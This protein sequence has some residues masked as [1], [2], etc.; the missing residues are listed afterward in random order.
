M[1]IDGGF[2]GSGSGGRYG[3]A[4]GGGAVYVVHKSMGT[5]AID[6]IH[7]AGGNIAVADGVGGT[8]GAIDALGALDG[9]RVVYIGSSEGVHGRL[10]G[11]EVERSGTR[12]RKLG[13]NVIESLACLRNA[14][15]VAHSGAGREPR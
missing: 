7:A 9:A 14:L 13:S 1:S 5:G 4:Y 15:E 3:I 2:N 6:G 12:P 10:G 8:T 11:G